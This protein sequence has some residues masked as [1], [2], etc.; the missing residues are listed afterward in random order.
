MAELMPNGTEKRLSLWNVP[1]GSFVLFPTKRMQLVPFHNKIAIP[2]QIPHE[3]KS[4][5]FA[6]TQVRFAVA[7]TRK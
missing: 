7:A 6:P 2:L 1:A 5:P 3:P 4:K